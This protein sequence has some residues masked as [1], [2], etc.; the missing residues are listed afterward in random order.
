MA[1]TW[2]WPLA[3]QQ[4]RAAIFERR[5]K[6]ERRRHILGCFETLPDGSHL[7]VDKPLATRYGYKRDLPI[8]SLFFAEFFAIVAGF[9]TRRTVGRIEA[10][11]ATS[12][13]IMQMDLA[14]AC[15]FRVARRMGSTCRESQLDVD[16]IEF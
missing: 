2:D 14:S 11:N 8:N 7:L 16:R 10:I 15:R 1:E 3:L 4:R 12:R 13:A 6:V 5:W 9:L